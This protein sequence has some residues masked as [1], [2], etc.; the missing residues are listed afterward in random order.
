[1]LTY[2]WLVA[3]QN[4]ERRT[5]WLIA[6]LMFLSIGVLTC[7]QA[8]WIVNAYQENNIRFKKG[9]SDA[10]VAAAQTLEE[11]ER[12]RVNDLVSLK[13]SQTTLSGTSGKGMIGGLQRTDGQTFGQGLTI[14]LNE[15][16][17]PSFSNATAQVEAFRKQLSVAS[18]A[19]MP[20]S[21]RIDPAHVEELVQEQLIRQGISLDYLFGIYDRKEKTF[22][23]FYGQDACETLEGLPK[24]ELR[25][26]LINSGYS[27]LLFERDIDPPGML[28]LHFPGK[29][30][31][32]LQT[33]LLNILIT[34]LCVL[35][36][37][38]C[39]TYVLS[40]IFKQKKVSEMKTDFINNMTHEFKTPIA[41]ISL[42]ADFIENPSVISDETKVKKF[43]NMIKEENTRMNKQVEKVLQIASL[44]K[45]DFKLKIEPCDVH[46]IIQDASKHIG[47]QVTKRGGTITTQLQASNFEI[48]ADQVHLTNMI[49]NLLD[50]AN[51]YS[52]E[53]P[54]IM[55]STRNK[56]ENLILSVSDKGQ[57][58][59]P[60]VQKRVFDR[61]YREHTGNRH[62]V[63]GFGLGLSYVKSIVDALGGTA[64]V[65][66]EKG[67][68][69]TFIIQLPL[70]QTQS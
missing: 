13:M 1:M 48:D 11:E 40:T 38:G 36:V 59:S 30:N 61:F 69:S 21:Q 45:D 34:I 41:T 58:M 49:H 55:I 60:D 9:V 53:S 14:K 35:I 5:L 70:R 67:K 50:N 63:K 27:A 24:E 7:L 31:Y 22:L 64:D 19:S 20:L 37:V 54:E 42:A 26:T 44:D 33:V 47:L 52:P 23:N 28:F 68:G 39:F 51:K 66:S 2:L 10:L 29:K 15:A 18:L 4:L 12:A 56:G 57:G 32:V 62:D 8:Y 65:N 6:I 25:E 43:I 16:E 46:E 3:M 17:T